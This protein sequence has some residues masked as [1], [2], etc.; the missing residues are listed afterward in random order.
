[1]SI[2][3]LTPKPNSLSARATNTV[4]D[5]AESLAARMT[6]DFLHLLGHEG[7]RFDTFEQLRDFAQAQI[8]AAAFAAA[9]EAKASEPA[10]VE[11]APAAAPAI[12][13][14]ATNAVTGQ[15]VPAELAPES[16]TILTPPP[17]P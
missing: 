3:I 1:M 13:G 11:P 12:A 2:I 7:H 14:D 6:S 10:P 16:I 15:G 8:D 17:Q 9:I 5:T 4:A